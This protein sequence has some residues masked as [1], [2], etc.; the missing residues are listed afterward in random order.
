MLPQA[1]SLLD[2]ML[3][4]NEATRIDVEGIRQHP[5][6]RSPMGPQ[7]QEAIEKMEAEQ[8]ANEVRCCIRAHI[9][10]HTFCIP[11]SPYP[12]RPAN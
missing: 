4:P 8:A 1:V 3:D 10:L 2:R 5:W 6:F 9:P 7:L 11:H 12:P